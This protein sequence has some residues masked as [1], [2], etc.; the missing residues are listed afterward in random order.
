MTKPVI[1]KRSTKGSPLTYTELD[2]N[3]QNLDDATVSLQAGT[4]GTVVASDLNGVITLVAGTGI[5]LSGNNTA[6]T[7]TIN[8]SGGEVVLDTSPQLGGD[9]DVNGFNI[10][11]SPLTNNPIRLKPN[12]VGDILLESDTVTVGNSIASQLISYTGQDLK[13]GTLDTTPGSSYVNQIAIRTGVNGN[14][15]L[16]PPGT[17][18]IQLNGPLKITATT[19]TPT[20]YQNGYYE[21]MLQTPV[22]WL[23]INI[24]G[25]DYY[26][27]LFQ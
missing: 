19:G 14:I 10:V 20:T 25:S 27:P 26:I 8:S 18:K 22:S 11:S 2:A 5:T 6:K 12:A 7:V 13:L 1:V 15:D 17:G 16:T 9:L 3:F 24:G 4:G 23:K 21:G